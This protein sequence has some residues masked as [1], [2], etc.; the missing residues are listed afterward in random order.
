MCVPAP[1]ATITNTPISTPIPSEP[2]PTPTPASTPASTPVP[3]PPPGAPTGTPG[4]ATPVATVTSGDSDCSICGYMDA[5]STDMCPDGQLSVLSW[6]TCLGRVIQC[7][8]CPPSST[9]SQTPISTQPTS[10]SVP[11]TQPAST[12]VP[13]PPPLPPPPLPP[14]N[15]SETPA[16][17]PTSPLP[18]SPPPPID[19]IG[20]Y[21]DLI[22]KY[23]WGIGQEDLDSKT[24]A[25]GEVGGTLCGYGYYYVLFGGD[26]Q[27]EGGEEFCRVRVGQAKIDDMWSDSCTINCSAGWYDPETGSGSFTLTAEFMGQSQSK[28]VYARPKL[29]PDGCADQ[30]VGTIT[31]YANGSFS[32]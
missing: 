19:I 4:I 16:V 11:P 5:G 22:V 24:S 7:R 13:P 3:P 28:T 17:T 30:S 1:T 15:P 21:D 10:T 18:T 14:P 12:S 23:S 26:D 31:V 6:V 25:F 20:Q 27:K 2:P 29:N 32:L 9:V 8:L